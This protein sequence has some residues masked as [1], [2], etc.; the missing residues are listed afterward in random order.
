MALRGHAVRQLSHITHASGLIVKAMISSLLDIFIRRL[1]FFAHCDNHSIVAS[2]PTNIEE[3]VGF[4]NKE[5]Y[6]EV[7]RRERGEVY[8]P[9]H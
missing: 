8:H 6:R 5:D 4:V 2:S 7:D 3:E 1:F 9:I